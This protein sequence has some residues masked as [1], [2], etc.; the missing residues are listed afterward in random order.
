MTDSPARS[1]RT[2]WM[3]AALTAASLVTIVV[4][5]VGVQVGVFAPLTSFILFSVGAVIGGILITLLGLIGVFLTR[6]GHDRLGARRSWSSFAIGAGMLIFLAIAAEPWAGYPPINDITNNIYHPPRF[7]A[8]RK[9]PV[10]YGRDFRYPA[11]FIPQAQAAYPDLK[12]LKLALP[13]DEAF[14]LALQVAQDMG[15]TI[16]RSDP[17][18]WVFEASDETAIF[19]FVDD[20]S[21][22]VRKSADGSA[23]DIR[24]KSRDG[25]GDLGANAKRIRAFEARLEAAA[26]SAS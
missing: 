13:R 7:E 17:N 24:S 19:R 16:L 25:Q 9:L 14:A 20:I 6:K 11:P 1:S 2:A 3:A 22:R 15:W 5:I 10:N 8:A 26:A 18:R 21:V 12:P 4:A 23:V